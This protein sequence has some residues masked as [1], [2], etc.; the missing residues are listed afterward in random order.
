M[1]RTK[2]FIQS[3][4][5]IGA[6]LLLGGCFGRTDNPAAP[7]VDSPAA[8]KTAEQLAVDWSFGPGTQ[9]LQAWGSE[10]TKS[11]E[12]LVVVSCYLRD[13]GKAK[14]WFAKMSKFYSDKC[15]SDKD[16]VKL[17]SETGKHQ[18]GIQGENK[19]GHYLIHEPGLMSIPISLIPPKPKEMVFAHSDADSTVTVFIWQQSDDVV[20]IAL[21]AAAR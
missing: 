17:N 1:V 4:P 13:D 3:A 2:H 21:T 14:D 12:K 20:M 18:L 6:A 5:W 10:M 11:G 9:K 8:P 15:G 19:S 16:P 7:K